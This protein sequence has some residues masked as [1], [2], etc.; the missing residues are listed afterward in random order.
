MQGPG[1]GVVVRAFT[2]TMQTL[3]YRGYVIS[4]QR[5]PSGWIAH[6][7]RPGGYVIMR[8]GIVRAT[9]VEDEENLLRLCRQRID[10]EERG[11]TPL[12]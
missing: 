10:E 1:T 2:G 7:R 6:I 8:N 12:E 4:F 5:K 11:T 3:T 9:D